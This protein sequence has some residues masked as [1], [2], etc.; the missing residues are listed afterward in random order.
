M[1]LGIIDYI[2]ILPVTCALEHGKVPFGGEIVKG[3]PSELNKK[4]ASGELDA[5][6]ISSIE[7]A[8]TG[9]VLGEHCIASHG[10]VKSVL[11]LSFVPISKI[12][13]IHL[14][15]E[16][17]TS[18]VLLKILMKSAFGDSPVYTEGNADAELVIGDAA[19]QKA[20]SRDYLLDLGK[21]WSEF[22]R[23]PM[24]FGVFA[25]KNGL[26]ADDK[27]KILSAIRASEEWGKKNMREIIDYA[28]R[29][30]GIDRGVVKEYYSLLSFTLGVGEK[31]GLRKFYENAKKLGEIGKAPF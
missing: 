18:S 8:R 17:A 31:R 7:F 9:G 19:L 12:K 28:S 30:A 24:V 22:S 26:H 25:Y 5:S 13:T 20:R 3:V 15:K 4:F 6:F 23:E 21:A 1:K 16:S 11:L 29:K 27:K 2:N 10:E 14:T